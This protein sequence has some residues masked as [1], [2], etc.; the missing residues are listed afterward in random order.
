MKINTFY[1]GADGVDNKKRTSAPA[2]SSAANFAE[3]LDRQVEG[4]ESAAQPSGITGIS[5]MPDVRGFTAEQTAAISRGE[6]ALDIL[7]HLG[8]ILQQN[9]P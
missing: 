7:E 4:Q 2:D 8:A 5:S 6:A 1:P 3:L 9:E